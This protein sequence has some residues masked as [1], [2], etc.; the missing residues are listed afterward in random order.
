MS[1]APPAPLRREA[2]YRSAGD[3]EVEASTTLGSPSATLR[4]VENSANAGESTSRDPE[5]LL[6]STGR[7][8]GIRMRFV[9]L[10]WDDF[11][12]SRLILPAN[13]RGSWRHATMRHDDL[14]DRSAHSPGVA[15]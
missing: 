2:A 1:V 13:T 10:R 5:A 3:G 14:D 9:D 8:L 11:G 7:N 6:A 4:P 15:R 12:T